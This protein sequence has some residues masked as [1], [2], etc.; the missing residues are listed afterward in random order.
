[1]TFPIKALLASSALVFSATAATAATA[2]ATTSV[3][4]RSGPGVQYEVV[5]TLPP[6]EVVNLIGCDGDW[7]E[8]SM[9]RDGS[10][11]AAAD[12]LDYAGGTRTRVI[13]EEDDPTVITGLSVGGY[14]EDRPYYFRD[15]YYYWGGRWYG[16]RPGVAGWRER[17]WRRWDDRRDARLDNRRDKLDDRKD[18]LDDRRDKL[19]DRRDKLN[20][21]GDRHDEPRGE[22][23]NNRH[24]GVRGWGGGDRGD[25]GGGR[26]EKAKAETHDGAN[27]GGGGRSERAE[28]RDRGD[29]VG[30]DKAGGGGGRGDAGRG[31]GRGGD[32]GRGDGGGGGHGDRGGG[33]F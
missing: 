26:P 6:G 2:T 15:G 7:C 10:G 27:R 5:D 22:R 29:R 19:N 4:V 8:I 33:R 32:G 17:S 20:D 1:M 13:V 25:G 12:Y 30:L 9:G 24:D 28:A 16:H 23:A 18:R 21:R 3:N 11:F 14:W 31:G